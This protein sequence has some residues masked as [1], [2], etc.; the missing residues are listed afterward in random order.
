MAITRREFLAGASG[1]AGLALLPVR[2][3]PRLTVRL[4]GPL[5][6]R[7][8][9]HEVDRLWFRCCV[10]HS[11][12]QV[13]RRG[14]D[15]RPL[16]R[17]PMTGL[18]YV[19]FPWAKGRTVVQQI[20]PECCRCDEDLDPDY[21]VSHSARRVAAFALEPFTAWR[22]QHAGPVYLRFPLNHH[23]EPPWPA[24]PEPETEDAPR[25]IV[26]PLTNPDG[27]ASGA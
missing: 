26:T 16:I 4:S 21:I 18:T 8:M 2:S 24:V 20:G 27:D 6:T 12:W 1:A 22:L 17:H 7:R 25:I 14:F 13:D 19:I 5:F 23:D 9:A 15:G 10:L 3:A 11:C